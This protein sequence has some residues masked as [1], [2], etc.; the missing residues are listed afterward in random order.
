[1]IIWSFDHLFVDDLRRCGA[2]ECKQRNRMFLCDARNCGWH[3]DCLAAHEGKG[4][5]RLP[6]PWFCTTCTNDDNLP[7]PQWGAGKA[8]KLVR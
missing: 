6:S 8:E 5:I 1:M 7:L 2:K 4:Y 3:R